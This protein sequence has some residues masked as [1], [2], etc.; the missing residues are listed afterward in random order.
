MPKRTKI[1]SDALKLLEEPGETLESAK[2]A[3]NSVVRAL[4]AGATRADCD[5]ATKAIREVRGAASVDK[6]AATV[7]AMK[8]CV[9]D[10]KEINKAAL[11]REAADRQHLSGDEEPLEDYDPGDPPTH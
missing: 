6:H 9:A 7:K 3:A 10:L 1:E 5:A 8:A 2:R 11:A 4:K